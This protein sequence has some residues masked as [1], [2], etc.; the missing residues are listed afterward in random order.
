[1]TQNQNST[2]KGKSE[3]ALHICVLVNSVFYFL[4]HVVIIEMSGK[5]RLVVLLN[6]KL[7]YERFYNSIRGA[8]IAF[9]KLFKSKAWF[10]DVKAIWTFFY[11]PEKPWLVEKFQIVEKS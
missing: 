10:K 5:Y 3:E 7:L 2:V 11:P 9:Q 4:S 6:N 8:K 1:M